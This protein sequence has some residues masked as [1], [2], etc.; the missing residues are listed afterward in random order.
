MNDRPLKRKY[1][2]VERERRFLLEQ[3]PPQL[4]HEE[5]QRFH[6]RYIIGA[7]VRLRRVETPGGEHLVTKLGQKI[8]NPDAPNNPRHQLMTTIYLTRDEGQVFASLPAHCASKRRYKLKEQGW[9]FCIDQYEAPASIAGLLIAEV[10]CDTDEALDAI[11][12]PAW[13]L[14]EIT[15]E[16]G[17]SGATLAASM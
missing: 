17:W 4:N 15:N 8:A 3:L 10:E 7:P 14:R 12:C 5:Y 16:Q 1:A 11:V 6:D 2:R 13:A 9:T